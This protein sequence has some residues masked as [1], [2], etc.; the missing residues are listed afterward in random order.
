[1][2]G[3]IR[4]SVVGMEN[5]IVVGSTMIN[6]KLVTFG[7]RDDRILFFVHLKSIK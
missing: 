4:E 2:L 6:M 5:Y 7:Y 1:M 3:R